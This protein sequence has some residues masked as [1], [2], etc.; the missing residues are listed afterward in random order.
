MSIPRDIV[1]AAQNAAHIS[2][3]NF[4]LESRVVAAEIDWVLVMIPPMVPTLWASALGAR[5]S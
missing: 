1:G 2:A 3:L 5:V 4:G